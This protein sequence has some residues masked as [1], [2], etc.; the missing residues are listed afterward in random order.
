MR[1]EA[2]AL[3][4]LL[5]APLALAQSGLDPWSQPAGGMER[6]GVAPVGGATLDVVRQLDLA[7][8]RLGLMG[9]GPAGIV[10]TP[11]GLVLAVLDGASCWLRWLDPASFAV[12]REARV[13][14]D[15]FAE[16]PPSAAA[17]GYDAAADILVVSAEGTLPIRGWDAATGEERW[18][19]APR[20]PGADGATGWVTLSAALDGARDE[21]VAGFWSPPSAIGVTSAFRLSTGEHLWSRGGPAATLLPRP[22]PTPLQGPVPTSTTPAGIVPEFVTA[23]R[24]AI[25]VRG[26]TA[27]SLALVQAEQPPQPS[28]AWYDRNGSV[29]GLLRSPAGAPADASQWAVAS[30]TQGALLYAGALHILNLQNDEWDSVPMPDGLLEGR[31]A[32]PPV[33]APPTLLVPTHGAVTRFDSTTL[34]PSWTWRAPEGAFVYHVVLAPPGDVYVLEAVVANERATAVLH[35]LEAST[36]RELQRL[37]LTNL[38]ERIRPDSFDLQLM[39][40]AATRSLLAW[41]DLG[42][43]ALLAAAPDAA[44]PQVRLSSAY[45]GVEEP[46]TLTVEG[47]A[48]EIVV[49]WGDGAI[50]TV[51]PGGTLAHQYAE[52]RP[53]TIRATAMMADGTTATREVVVQV[54]TTPPQHLSAIQRAFSPENQELTF[55]L[56]GLAVTGGGVL[57]ATL[58]RRQ[59]HARLS[60]EERRLRAVIDDSLLNPTSGLAA[61]ERHRAHLRDQH[62]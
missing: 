20:V 40:I 53:Y 18:S 21:V 24:D 52:R 41:S 59:R 25:L 27:A 3:A 13:G 48:A 1:A 42:P 12:R 19:A 58:L 55:F 8:E 30:G 36:G 9:I 26:F 7:E 57:F 46:L 11:H 14:C 50:E 44:K 16:E 60:D 39:P 43:A 29:V 56:L 6:R 17:L 23:S 49:A 35:R 61:L 45:P 2:L 54:G 38:A 37:P 32:A 34:E 31:E 28:I 10:E 47:A 33:W 15:A 51:A 4:F 22:P 62:T 5:L